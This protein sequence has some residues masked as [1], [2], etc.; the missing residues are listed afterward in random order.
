MEKCLR[1]VDKQYRRSASDHVQCEAHKSLHSIT[2]NLERRQRADR[3]C[4]LSRG[5]VKWGDGNPRISD[6]EFD[7]SA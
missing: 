6:T 3:L 5:A 7:L 2:L 4:I 1:F